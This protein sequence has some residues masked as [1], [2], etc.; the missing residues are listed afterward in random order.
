MTA[1]ARTP[2]RRITAEPRMSYVVEIGG[3]RRRFWTVTAAYYALAKSLLGKKYIGPMRAHEAFQ[4][5]SP[6]ETD[7]AERGA[8][9]FCR[10]DHAAEES[11][12]D[13]DRWQA[14]VRRVARKMRALDERRVP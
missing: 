6:E 12:F 5:L 7:R 2:S 13:R 3:K 11:Y 1:D 8:A 9:L 4:D 10:L 14:Y